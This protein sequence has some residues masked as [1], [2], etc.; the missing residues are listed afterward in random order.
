VSAKD[1]CGVCGFGGADDALSAI[2]HRVNTMASTSY[3]KQ[4]AVFIIAAGVLFLLLFASFSSKEYLSISKSNGNDVESWCPLPEPPSHLED[5]LN[6]SSSFAE[7][8]SVLKQVERL[9]AATN[10]ST[11]SYDDNGDV[12]EDPRWKSFGEFHEVLRHLFPLVSVH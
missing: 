2:N 5:G 1:L 3:V 4:L 10:V 12:D 7:K 8:T 11:V 9:S 6:P